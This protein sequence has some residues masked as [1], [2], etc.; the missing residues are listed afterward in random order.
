MIVSKLMM[1]R[2]ENEVTDDVLVSF[3]CALE[4]CRISFLVLYSSVLNSK[5]VGGA[6]GGGSNKMHQGGNY[7]DFWG[8]LFLFLLYVKPAQPQKLSN[9]VLVK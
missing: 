1:Q 3:S 2:S 5:G 6:G 7:Q 9:S 4:T 8:K